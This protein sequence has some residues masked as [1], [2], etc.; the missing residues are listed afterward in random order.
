MKRIYSLDFLKF[1]M[2][3]L[4]VFHHYQQ[5]TGMRMVGINFYEGKIY[6]GSLV[7]LFFIISGFFAANG[8]P[9]LKES[10]FKDY[11]V[12]KIIRIYP[13]AMMSVC[14]TAVAGFVYVK[15]CGEWFFGIRL[16]LWKFV[17]SLLLTFAGGAVND[18]LGI[19]DPLW[20]LCVLMYCYVLLYF[21]V[22]FCSRIGVNDIYAFALMVILGLSAV[23]YGIELPFLNGYTGRGYLAFFLGILLFRIWNS[24]SHKIL[25]GYSVVVV[26]LSLIIYIGVY[27]LF[28]AN[29][30]EVF[31]FV[32]Y[33]AIMFLALSLDEK[34]D[35]GFLAAF[36]FGALA[37]E[38]YIW[39]IFG[40][41]LLMIVSSAT[42]SPDI[43]KYYFMFVYVVI[44]ILF[45]AVM[46]NFAEKKITKL[47]NDKLNQC[48]KEQ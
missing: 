28:I 21:L 12:K 38:M 45:A 31:A 14:M 18:G 11:I 22:W 27:S 4:I 6:W 33:P 17:N 48:K 24:I 29:Q 23:Q 3:I 35:L 47:I 41:C 10:A 44:L 37:F 9:A 36:N 25:L 34:F 15:V 7:E 1:I 13:M 42:G 40:I 43:N 32:V 39:H 8:I 46:Y 16:T 5:Y 30:R 2:A 19:N 20:Y 26:L